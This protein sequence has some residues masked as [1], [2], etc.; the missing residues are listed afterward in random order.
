MVELTYFYDDGAPDV[1]NLPKPVLDALK[2]LTFVDD[3]Q[4]TDLL[5]RKRDLSSNLRVE[6]A[7]PIMAAGFDLGS[8]FI[9]VVVREA[10]RQEVTV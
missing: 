7:T 5:V 4:V 6:D 3:D 10:P 8:P 1:D 2:G 9:H